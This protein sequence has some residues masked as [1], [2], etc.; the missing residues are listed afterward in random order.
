MTY[1]DALTVQSSPIITLHGWLRIIPSDVCF[2]YEIYN[3]H[4]ALVNRYPELK[5][6]N[7]QEVVINEVGR[8]PIIGSIIHKVVAEVDA[9]EILKSIEVPNFKVHNREVIYNVLRD[10]SLRTWLDFLPTIL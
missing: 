2:Y 3:G 8:Y 4:P 7:M 1:F 9:G 10:T 5:G 6:K